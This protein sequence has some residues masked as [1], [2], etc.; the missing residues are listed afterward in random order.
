[1]MLSVIATLPEKAGGLGGGVLYIDTESAF[2]AER[3]VLIVL[4]IKHT[5]CLVNFCQNL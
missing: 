3:L 1:M 5:E 2:S 4:R